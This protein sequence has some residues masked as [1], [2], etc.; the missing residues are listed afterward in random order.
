MNPIHPRYKVLGAAIVLSIMPVSFA[1]AQ[2]CKSQIPLT[3]PTT[4]FQVH[5]NGTVTHTPTGLMW[6]VCSE[7]QTWQS[8][9][10]CSGEA[11]EH[12][13]QAALQ[14]PQTLNTEG[15]FAGHT[16][17]RLPNI[18]ELKSI[19][20]RACVEPAINTAVFNHTPLTSYYWTSTP[21]NSDS[22]LAYA[23]GFG[24]GYSY[25]LERTWSSY[26]HV[27]LVRGGQ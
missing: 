24:T 23:V 26:V 9:G 10:R 19:V 16:D 17:W 22:A 18:K 21:M 1:Q 3:K 5:N 25:Q 4:D 14:I 15:G 7:G 20:E 2:T 13:W 12:N 6:K 27:R 8:D 11:S